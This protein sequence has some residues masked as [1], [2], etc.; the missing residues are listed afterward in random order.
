MSEPDHECSVLSFAIRILN[1]SEMVSPFLPSPPNI[2]TL[3]KA[4]LNDD[5]GLK[6][7]RIPINFA[8]GKSLFSSSCAT[9]SVGLSRPSPL[10]IQGMITRSPPEGLSS[11][12]QFSIAGIE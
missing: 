11:Y 12:D 9:K 6:S 10:K 7:R 4:N 1:Q 8:C 2:I 5:S 3:D